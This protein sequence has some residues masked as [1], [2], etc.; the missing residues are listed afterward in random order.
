M[1]G[2]N[3]TIG[4]RLWLLGCAVL[5]QGGVFAENID[6]AGDGSQYA[7]GENAGW[8]DFGSTAPPAATQIETGWTCPDPDA[9]GVCSA[10][11]SCPT[12]SNTNQAAVL[13]GQ[14]VLA[15]DKNNFNWPV[16]VEFELATGTFTTSAS[17]G[18]WAVDFYDTGLGA[19]YNDNGTPVPGT[20]YWYVFRPDCP[21]GSYSTGSPFEVPGRDAALVP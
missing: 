18:A 19:L 11:D 20:G 6:P 12:F 9:D 14:T 15:L 7:W 1:F 10:S 2:S 3:S 13:F 5:L 8:I 21:A 16:A 17:I 4:P